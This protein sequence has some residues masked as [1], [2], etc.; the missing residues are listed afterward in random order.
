MADEAPQVKSEAVDPLELF[1]VRIRERV[2]G[3]AFL[4]ELNDT[5][6][7]AGHSFGLRTLRPHHKY[8][9]AQAIQPMRNTIAEVDAWRDAHIGIALTHVDGDYEFCPPVG[10]N[11]QSFVEGRWRFITDEQTGWYK[12]VLDFLWTEYMR[13]EQQAYEA[14]QQLDFLSKTK[15]PEP[16]SVDLLDSSTVP[17]ILDALTNSGFQNFQNSNAF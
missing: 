5:V 3:L 9:I 14:V 10:P 4:G 1:D 6:L 17:D 13:L 12:P 7:Y 8:A 11:L 16:L 2:R 15:G